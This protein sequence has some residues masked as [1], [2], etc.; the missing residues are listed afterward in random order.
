MKQ[1]SERRSPSGQAARGYTKS[2]LGLDRITIG[3]LPMDVVNLAG[4]VD[5]IE[6]MITTRTG[7]NVFTPNVDHICV[8]EENER[9]RRV[10]ANVSLSLVDGA[11]VV[12]ASRRLGRPLPERVAGSDLLMPLLERAAARGY[13]VYLLGGLPGAAELAAKRLVEKLPALQI[14][15][16]EGPRINPDDRGPERDALV[17]RVAGARPDIV[18]VGLGAPKQEFWITA[19]FDALR[20]AVLLAIG[21]GIDFEA[22]LLK[23]APAWMS[24]AGLEWLYRLSQDPKRLASRYLLRDPKFALVLARE[25]RA[26]RANAAS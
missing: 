9:F 21:A 1:E 13:R 12:W 20:P 7:G 3:H 17:A 22:G 10:Y 18:L 19:N 16:A 5:A 25:W 8:A 15:G 4:A 24:R 26:A 2:P 6:K 11:P 23:R 14:V